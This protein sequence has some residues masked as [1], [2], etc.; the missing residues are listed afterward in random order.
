MDFSLGNKRQ[1]FTQLYRS[2]STQKRIFWFRINRY[3]KKL[4]ISFRLLSIIYKICKNHKKWSKT[5]ARRAVLIFQTGFSQPVDPEFWI[6]L[7]KD[8]LRKKICPQSPCL[9]SQ[10]AHSLQNVICKI[11]KFPEILFYEYV[12]MTTNHDNKYRFS[13]QVAAKKTDKKGGSGVQVTKRSTFFRDRKLV[14]STLKG[15]LNRSQ[16]SKIPS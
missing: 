10:V 7:A 16:F 13:Q 11:L 9:P 6:F 8:N 15:L 14:R 12:Q 4:L 2:R 3:R 1:R 5:A